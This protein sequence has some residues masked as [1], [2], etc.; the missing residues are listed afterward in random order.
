[1]S[2]VRNAWYPAF[3]SHDLGRTLQQRVML[4]EKIVFYRTEAGA[5][6]ALEDRCCHKYMPLSMGKLKGQIG[7]LLH[8]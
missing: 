2:F 3:W 1:M 6:V 7:V 4:G 5:P 8:K